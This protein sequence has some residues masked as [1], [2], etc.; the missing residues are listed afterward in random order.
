MHGSVMS[1]YVL[2]KLLSIFYHR[3]HQYRSIIKTTN[4][5]NSFSNN[6]IVFFL[7]AACVISIYVYV[8]SFC[9]DWMVLMVVSFFL[10]HLARGYQLQICHT[11]TVWFSTNSTTVM[12]YYLDSRMYIIEK[13]T[14]YHTFIS[15]TNTKHV[16]T[17]I[18]KNIL[19]KIC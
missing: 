19:C 13:I 15:K 6:K 16:G 4:F 3:K 12:D 1:N 10:T 14:F 9:T 11:F 7:F 18:I 5:V 17:S 8:R 2:Y